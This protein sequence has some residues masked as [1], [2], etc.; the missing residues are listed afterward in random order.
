MDI[1]NKALL[2]FVR[3]AKQHLNNFDEI[4]TKS[5]SP[6]RGSA[7]AKEMNRFNFDLDSFLH[8]ECNVPLGKT[9]A[10]LNKSFRFTKS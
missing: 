7:L 9:Q 10:V 4:M 3:S 5:E 6:Q 1:S 2:Q 8:F